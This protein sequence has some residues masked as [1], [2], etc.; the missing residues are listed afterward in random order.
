MRVQPTGFGA[1][2]SAAIAGLLVTVGL[3]TLKAQGVAGDHE[4]QQ[5]KASTQ[6]VCGKCHN[7]QIVLNAAMSYDAWH[8]TVQAMIDR[9]AEGSDEQLQDVMDYLHRTSTT[10]NVN[11]ADGAELGIV[12]NVPDAVAQAII[13]RRRVRPFK[14]LADLKTVRGLDAAALEMRSRLLFF[15]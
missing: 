2:R 14:D 15:K 5:E 3:G 1:L 8:D 13:A 7:L 11:A 12:L 4:L 6:A 10:I 9:G